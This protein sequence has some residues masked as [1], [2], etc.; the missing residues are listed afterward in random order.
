MLFIYFKPPSVTWFTGELT[1]TYEDRTVTTLDLSGYGVAEQID[2]LTAKQPSDTPTA[3]PSETPSA[4]PS[5]TPTATN[6]ATNTVTATATRTATPTTMWTF[7][8]TSM[9]TPTA[10]EEHFTVPYTDTPIRTA[11]PNAPSTSTATVTPTATVRRAATG[12]LNTPSLGFGNAPVGTSSDLQ[13]VT[14]S[15]GGDAPLTVS[16]VS[17]S[18]PQQDSF[19]LSADT[20]QEVLAPDAS[21]S[22][23]V[24]FHPSQ[25]G[26]AT[27]TL[28]FVDSAASRPANRQSDRHRRHPTNGKRE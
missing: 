11:T 9:V 8:I 4:S 18:G 6:S 14:L 21:C 17:L 20:C 23:Q 26:S 22:V 1:I 3:T 10:T 12:N 16:T 19:V 2:H 28:Q 13:N 27:A 15:N 24:A 25:I 5:E 7:V